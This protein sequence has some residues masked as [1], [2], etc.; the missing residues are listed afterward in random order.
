MFICFFKANIMQQ[1]PRKREAENLAE[2]LAVH[3]KDCPIPATHDRLMELHHW[4][5]EIARW[6][7]EP[8]PF[9]YRLGAFIQAA[10]SLTF[11]LQAE[12]A[13]Y[14]DFGWYEKW[15]ANAKKDPLFNW[16][17]EI[18]VEYVH[19]QALEPQ[20]WLEMR[21]LDNP[22]EYF[23]EDEDPFRIKVSPFECTHYYINQGPHCDHAHEFIRHWSLEGLTGREVL[24]AFADIYDCLD[25]LVRVAHEQVGASMVSFKQNNSPRSL[26]CMDN[27]D[28]HRIVRTEIK[29]GKEVWI[30]EPPGLHS[31]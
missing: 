14:P 16:L 5:H 31:H 20:S 8:E 10:R 21:C 29:D 18:R 24:E 11:M 17:N 23:D 9:R 4:W 3:G 22:S 7:H 12:K 6:Y 2:N 28:V 1:P 25:D 27:L 15:V 26:P 30:D 19:R 13:V